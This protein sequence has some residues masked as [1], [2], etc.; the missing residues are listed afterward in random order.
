MTFM[1]LYYTKLG[2]QETAK[3]ISIFGGF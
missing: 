1:L 2:S 3:H